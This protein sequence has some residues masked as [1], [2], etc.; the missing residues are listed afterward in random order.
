MS[1]EPIDRDRI[2][3]NFIFTVANN[4]NDQRLDF[5]LL[6]QLFLSND[7]LIDHFYLSPSCTIFTEEGCY[8]EPSI[9][10]CPEAISLLEELEYI[11][12][13]KEGKW[14][15]TYKGL[16]YVANAITKKGEPE[17]LIIRALNG[18]QE[19]IDS[20]VEYFPRV[21]EWLKNVSC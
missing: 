19:D 6:G 5:N 4:L 17:E 11:T 21:G 8:N 16:K 18:F 1:Q 10:Y 15:A 20:I 7:V 14:G 2:F 9:F 3:L 12:T 13:N